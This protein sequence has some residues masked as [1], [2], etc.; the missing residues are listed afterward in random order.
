MPTIGA[1]GDAG[2]LYIVSGKERTYTSNV[3]IDLPGD[4]T[5][6]VCLP[7]FPMLPTGLELYVN[8]VYALTTPEYEGDLDIVGGYT[9]PVN[10]QWVGDGEGIPRHTILLHFVPK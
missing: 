8:G 1:E 5:L 4:Y 3:E 6:E 2:L 9:S 7:P 10:I